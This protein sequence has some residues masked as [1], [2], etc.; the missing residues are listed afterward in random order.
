MSLQ[1]PLGRFLGHGSAKDGTEHWWMQ[2]VT[3]VALV[4][5]TLWFV[6]TILTLNSLDHATVAAWATEPFSA[7]MLILLLIAVLYHSQLGL[8]VVVEDYVHTGWTKVSTLMLF[9][10]VHIALGVAGIYS[11]LT[12]P[13]GAA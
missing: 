10:L 4:P 11:I 12:I 8:Q 6:V 2:R 1:S 9:K 5:L 3:A 13:T 7:I